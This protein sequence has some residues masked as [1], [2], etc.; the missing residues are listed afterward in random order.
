MIRRKQ[1]GDM[2]GQSGVQSQGVSLE[3]AETRVETGCCPIS[4]IARLGSGK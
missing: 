4:V 3:T 1:D 2:V